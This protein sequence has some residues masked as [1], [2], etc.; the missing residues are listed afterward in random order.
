MVNGASPGPAPADQ[1]LLA[2]DPIQLADVAPPE[3]RRNVP[4]VDG[5]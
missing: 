1:A 4:R 3:L 2:A 5:V